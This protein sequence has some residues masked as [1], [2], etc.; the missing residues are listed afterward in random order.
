MVQDVVENVEGED[1]RKIIDQANSINCQF[2]IAV[3]KE[4]LDSS[5]ISQESQDAMCIL[6]LSERDKLFQ[7]LTVEANERSHGSE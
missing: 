4:K 3:L 2:I 1:L 7:G 5:R 6:E